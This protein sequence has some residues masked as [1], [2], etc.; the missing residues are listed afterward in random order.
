MGWSTLLLE[1]N[2]ACDCRSAVVSA[3]TAIYLQAASKSG[4]PSAAVLTTLYSKPEQLALGNEWMS[5]TVS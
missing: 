5:V 2:G 3:R 4:A 1:E